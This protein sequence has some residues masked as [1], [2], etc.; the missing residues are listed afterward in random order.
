MQW[1]EK[2]NR[3]NFIPTRSTVVCEKHFR[4]QDFVP[5]HEN[6]DYRKRPKKRKSL[7]PQAVPLLFLKPPKNDPPP[8]PTRN[9]GGNGVDMPAPVPPPAPAPAPAPGLAPAA[10]PAQNDEIF[11]IP[12][13]GG[14]VPDF[15]LNNVNVDHDRQEQVEIA[16][17]PPIV[18]VVEDIQ[19]EVEVTTKVETVESL[20]IQLQILIE[21][22][23]SL[24]QKNAALQKKVDSMSRVFGPDQIHRLEHP[25]SRSHWSDHTLEMSIILYYKVGHTGY[26]YLREVLHWPLPCVATINNHMSK[27]S[28]RPGDNR[29]IM[30]LLSL[31]VK[32]M[33][34]K[35]RHICVIIDEMSI[36]QKLEYS[37]TTGEMVGYPTCPPH[38]N[39]VKER[40]RKGIDQSKI[41]A[42]HVFNVMIQGLFLRFVNLVDFL[43]TDRSWCP[44][45]I[46]KR[47]FTV[48]GQ[49]SEVGLKTMCLTMDQGKNNISL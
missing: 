12:V 4:A 28:F 6:L 15:V 49:L 14:Q 31:K 40:K 18:M 45:F 1:L 36:A 21:K 13:I 44:K 32:D 29:D 38:P 30:K 24:T 26:V 10:A 47:L 43:F 16:D 48:F 37:S 11:Q 8:R 7:K 41:L 20:Q 9:S 17:E 3:Q 27:I 22:N 42:S 39:L 19:A 2:I 23:E 46:A 5:A 25:S 35:D 34:E 33:S